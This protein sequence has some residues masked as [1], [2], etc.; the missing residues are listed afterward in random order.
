[1]PEAVGIPAGDEGP[2]GLPATEGDLTRDEII[3]EI[4]GLRADQ[5]A[6]LVALLWL[7]RGDGEPEE[8]RELALF[9]EERHEMPTCDYLLDHPHVA[10]HWSD[11]LEKL[12]HGS[13]ISGVGEL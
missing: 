9:A 11:G 12:G 5:Q 7:G 1:M 8:W 2:A 10:D 4:E 3:A 13:I 6:E